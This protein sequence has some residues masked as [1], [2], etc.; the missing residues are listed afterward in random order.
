MRVIEPHQF[1]SKNKQSR[2][3][4]KGYVIGLFILALIFGV[5]GFWFS[6]SQPGYIGS[7]LGRN[8][9]VQKEESYRYLA[10]PEFGE[11]YHQLAFPNTQAIVS[12]PVIT[13][14]M[15]ADERIRT[16]AVSRGYS[17]TAVPVAPIMKVEQELLQPRAAEAWQE[18]ATAAHTTNAELRLA[19][20]YRSVD[21]QRALFSDQLKLHKVAVSK[22]VDGSA[23]STLVAILRTTAI[24]G[25]SRHHTGY[26]VDLACGNDSQSFTETDCYTWLSQDNYANAKRHGWIPSYPEGESQHVPEA[27]PA[28]FSWVGKSVLLTQ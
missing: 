16:I 6:R 26:T 27:E 3:S 8:Q 1:K 15:T 13:G 21:V 14:N 4:K 11:L 12:E 2:K 28:Q 19:S 20:G 7:V 25:Y 22:I 10:V 5:C 18:M 24:P 17:R 23:D 9:S